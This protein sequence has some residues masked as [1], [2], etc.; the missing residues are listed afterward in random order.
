MPKTKN[1]KY[2]EGIGGRKTASARVRIYPDMKGD[3]D[4]NGKKPEDYFQTEDQIKKAYEALKAVELDGIR[5]TGSIKGGGMNAQAAAF[6]HGLARS[7]EQYNG[8]FRKK[9][10]SL[11][12]LTRDSRQKERKKPGKSGARR[13]PQWRKR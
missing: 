13:S 4:I 12:Y 10:K 1:V 8:E 3:F 5:V 7:L 2:Y 9:L 11:G 6:R